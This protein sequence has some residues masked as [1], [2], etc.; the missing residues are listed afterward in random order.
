MN[1]EE[2]W[3]ELKI[4]LL[5]K[6]RLLKE[7]DTRVEFLKLRGQIVSHQFFSLYP[8]VSK[9]Q[10]VSWTEVD[11]CLGPPLEKEDIDVIH[12]LWSPKSDSNAEQ[13][14]VTPPEVKEEDSKEVIKF[15]VEKL[16]QLDLSMM[17][18]TRLLVRYKKRSN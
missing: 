9:L 3:H 15:Q 4:P 8:T 7:F 13:G 17:E 1:D 2:I 11:Q 18:E 5:I 6:K 10:S 16:Y 14:H 12:M